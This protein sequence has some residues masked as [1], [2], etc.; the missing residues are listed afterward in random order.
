MTFGRKT[1]AIIVADVNVGRLLRVRTIASS[2]PR[3]DDNF[4]TTSSKLTDS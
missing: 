2:G 1:V 4:S 3:D